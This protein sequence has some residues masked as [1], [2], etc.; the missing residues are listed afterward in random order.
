MNTT[1][2]NNYFELIEA[3]VSEKLDIVKELLERCTF[4]QAQLD[5]AL[6]H[7]CMMRT[8]HSEDILLNLVSALVDAGANPEA[9]DNAAVW[10]ACKYLN[11]GAIAFIA[12]RP[13]TSIETK[14]LILRLG[15][16]YDNWDIMEEIL[17]IDYPMYDA[18]KYLV[19]AIQD[20]SYAAV[21]YIWA[22]YE[23]KIVDVLQLAF[24]HKS[25]KVI[26][27]FLYDYKID[28]DAH[29]DFKSE[30]DSLISTR[31]CELASTA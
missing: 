20:D 10:M 21:S 29:E 16:K 5:S 11:Y 28:P 14:E 13:N 31:M 12:N 27:K 17:Y 26:E 9:D 2:G 24:D 1:I 30:I 3:L 25:K 19:Y 22:I 18:Q 6:L 23:L 7:A 8:R 15:I 4:T